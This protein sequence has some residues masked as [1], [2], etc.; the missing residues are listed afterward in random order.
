MQPNGLPI[1]NATRSVPLPK[2]DFLAV[3]R[4]HRFDCAP[5]GVKYYLDGQLQHIDA[6]SIP[7]AAGSVQLN[8]WSDGNKYWSGSASTT[9]VFMKVKNL[10]VYFNTT[11]TDAGTDKKWLDAC[12][13]A[14]GGEKSICVSHTST[15]KESCKKHLAR[16]HCEG[17]RVSLNRILRNVQY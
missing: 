7:R 3:Y 1:V 8:L 2:D 11:A 10:L 6:H 9:D 17:F 5:E 12:R 4:E 14:G 16:S 13:A 15:M